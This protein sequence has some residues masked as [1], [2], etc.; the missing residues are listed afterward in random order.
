V[1][2][3]EGHE[4]IETGP[5]RVVRHPIYSGLLLMVLGT[6]ILAGRL[7][8]LVAFPIYLLSIWIKLRWEEALMTKHFPEYLEYKARTKALVPFLL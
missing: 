8:G 4:L 2:F 6:A 3:K 5:Y 1:T 7:G